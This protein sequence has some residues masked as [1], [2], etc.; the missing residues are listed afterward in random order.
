MS[1][2]LVRCERAMG[3]WRVV[4]DRAEKANAL[5]HDMLHR[6]H[7]IFIEAAADESLR[8]LTITGAGERAFCGGADLSEL[9]T[10]PDDPAEAIWEEMAGALASLP[11]VTVAAIN[12]ACIGGGMTLA[13]ACNM[14]VSV[15][16]AVFAY[17]AL[18]NGVLPGAQDCKRL[19]ALIGP[20][21]A[22]LLLLAGERIGA[23]EAAAWGL[24]DRLSE[25]DALTSTVSALTAAARAAER[26]H[27]SA[28]KEL[29]RGGPP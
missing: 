19:D 24:V 28:I 23:D 6:L 4:L 18:R 14:R 16:E 13:L 5:T 25:R 3:A 20:G 8:A 21:R 29:C 27:V 12:G 7:Q 15:P 17:P 9:S 26:G 22:A 10:D 2:D 1:R 11:V